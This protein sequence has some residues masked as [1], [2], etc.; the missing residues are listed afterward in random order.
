M[1]RS[2]VPI[3]DDYWQ[4][5]PDAY[6]AQEARTIAA[7]LAAGESG[8]IVGLSGAGRATLLSFL[9]HRPDVLQSL[10][11]P[12]KRQVV[13]APVDLINLPDNTLATLYRA[14]LRSFY[15]V[16]Y[17]FDR[18]LQLHIRDLYR[19]TE[20]ARDPFLPQSALRELLLSLEA[21]EIRIGLIF[22]R[23]DRFCQTA[24]VRM[25]NTLRGLR[26]SFKETLCYLVSLPQEI[27]Y[28]PQWESLSPLQGILDTHTCWVGP[29]C[30]ADARYMIAHRTRHLPE[31]LT[32]PVIAR[33]LAITGGYPSLLRVVCDWWTVGETAVTPPHFHTPA[34]WEAALLRQQNTRH[35]LGEIWH[36]LTQE[37][38]L[39]LSEL[40]K[41]H[42]GQEDKRRPPQASPQPAIQ[43][44]E[45]LPR[46]GAKGVCYQRENGVWGV[47]GRLLNA[48][49]A[50]VAGRSRGKIW[51]DVTGDV[52]QGTARIDNLPPLERAV[53]HFFIQ[54]PQ[55]RHT[56]TDLI[57]AAWPDDVLKE[58]VSTETLYQTIRGIRKKIE[59][60]PSNPYYILNWRGQREGGYH[61][62][63]EGRPGGTAV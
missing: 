5:Y 8:V 38:Q 26:D 22:D 15:E 40:Q 37:E 50:Q 1:S 42:V 47:N 49:V 27:Q 60:Q 20:T 43:R 24:T 31:P 34:D 11:A 28:L 48:Y 32:E 19:K 53:L 58:G 46:L 39:V 17:R 21:E 57:E 51:L 7:W 56:H 54:H 18:S 30:A 55:K 13:L 63:P 16:S 45:L 59:P 4:H 10:L 41:W 25:T 44:H 35:R 2:T 62:F 61:F 33:M 36:G 23:F 14:I 6:R 3:P 12:Y 52:Y 29:L 9:C